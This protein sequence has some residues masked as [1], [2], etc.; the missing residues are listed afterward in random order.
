[1]L[2]PGQ[3]LFH[4]ANVKQAAQEAVPVRWHV[5]NC[6]SALW[7]KETCG[8]NGWGEAGFHTVPSAPEP[9]RVPFLSPGLGL[10]KRLPDP[11]NRSMEIFW[12]VLKEGSYTLEQHSSNSPLDTVEAPAVWR[13][14]DRLLHITHTNSTGCSDMLK[15]HLSKLLSNC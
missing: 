13:T 8:Q 1:M 9:C 12:C 14:S 4:R 3:H 5:L 2:S 11:Q 6:S 10:P 15:C 7:P